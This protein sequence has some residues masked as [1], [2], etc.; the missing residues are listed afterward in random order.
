VPSSPGLGDGGDAS[1]LV[2]SEL[3]GK[4]SGSTS[5]VRPRF[6]QDRL[7]ARP[8]RDHRANAAPWLPSFSGHITSAC[9][10]HSAA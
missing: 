7:H 8:G 9:A 6:L 5:P 3:M 1:A 10:P 4:P 2:R